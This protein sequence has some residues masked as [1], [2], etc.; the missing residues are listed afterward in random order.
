METRKGEKMIN[1]IIGLFIGG[2]F[3]FFVACIIA[4]SSKADEKIE[5]M[6]EDKR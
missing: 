6:R 4:A 2:I 3:G 5:R 1:F